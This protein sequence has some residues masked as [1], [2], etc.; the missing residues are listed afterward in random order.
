MMPMYGSSW[1]PPGALVRAPYVLLMY[2]LNLSPS[3]VSI[4]LIAPFET[5]SLTCVGSVGPGAM[6]G[7]S[8]P[9]EMPLAI[10]LVE[11]R[12]VVTWT[13]IP[14][15][16]SNGASTSRNA[17]SS[18]PPQAVQTVTSVDDALFPLLLPLEP[19]EH[20]AASINVPR[21]SAIAL[22]LSLDKTSAIA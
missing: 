6:S 9:A 3:A 15:S 14:L 11:S 20:A 21:P 19:L 17:L 10:W 16:F 22:E 4:G 7:R 8:V 13:L 18:A 2:S 5:Q 1:A 12:F